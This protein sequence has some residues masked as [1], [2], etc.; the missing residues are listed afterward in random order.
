MIFFT[1][2]SELSSSPLSLHLTMQ[3]VHIVPQFF[4][5]KEMYQE[6]KPHSQTLRWFLGS[7]LRW[8]SAPSPHPFRHSLDGGLGTNLS[9]HN[10]AGR[11]QMEWRRWGGG[12][13]LEVNACEPA[14]LNPLLL[15]G[16]S[17]SLSLRWVIR[18]LFQVSWIMKPCAVYCNMWVFHEQT[19][20]SP[21]T[22]TVRLRSEFT[23][24]T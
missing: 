15:S 12:G 18:L 8:Q 20:V 5:L 22:P 21:C 24:H 6:M 23:P 13:G 9:A 17:L 14:A 4:F 16:V 19:T 1:S 10:K 7:L 2:G 11:L 3:A